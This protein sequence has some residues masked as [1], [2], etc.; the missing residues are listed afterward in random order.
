MMCCHFWV[1]D[2]HGKGTCRKCGETRQFDTVEPQSSAIGWKDYS[3]LL[4]I[5]LAELQVWN[6]VQA[7]AEFSRS[8]R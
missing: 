4:N 6:N 7:E 5:R 3:T 2:A 8:R 1:I